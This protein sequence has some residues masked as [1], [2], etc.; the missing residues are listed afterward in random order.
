[1]T[2][3]TFITIFAWI[4]CIYTSLIVFISLPTYIS[5]RVTQKGWVILCLWILSLW[6]LTCN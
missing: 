6:W 3:H 5:L 2:T 4:A 1:M